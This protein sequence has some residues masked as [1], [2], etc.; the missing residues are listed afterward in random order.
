MSRA[1]FAINLHKLTENS[2]TKIQHFG[3]QFNAKHYR[4]GNNKELNIAALY[5][6]GEFLHFL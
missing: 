5:S 4:Q 3:L 2:T 1:N 6:F